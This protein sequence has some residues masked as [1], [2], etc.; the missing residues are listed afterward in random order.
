MS[1][2][3]FDFSAFGEREQIRKGRIVMIG[4]DTRLFYAINS[5][6]AHGPWIDWAMALVAQYGPVVFGLALL[7]QWSLPGEG[8]RERRRRVVLGALGA[9]VALSLAQVVG[10]AYFRPRPF[11]VLP[12]VHL[13]LGHGPDTSF[14]SDHATISSAS[15]YLLAM[16]SPWWA[17][18]SWALVALI[19]FARVFAGVHYPLDVI[20]GIVLGYTV[21][22]GMYRGRELLQSLTDK[23]IGWAETMTPP[24][25]NRRG[26][27]NSMAFRR[28]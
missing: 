14:P 16:E 21:A 15:A 17:A 27:R 18:G 12:G 26:K 20:G 5:L 8:R 23:V 28:Y 19:G 4:F 6:A 22:C 25:G 13:L 11:M 10:L 2:Q 7:V 1:I 9:A 24:G 3:Q